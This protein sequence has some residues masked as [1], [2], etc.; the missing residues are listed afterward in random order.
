MSGRGYIAEEP[1]TMCAFCGT[2][3]ECRP[4]GADHEQICFD[5]AMSTPERKAMAERRMAEYI[6]GEVNE[7]NN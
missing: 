3:T 7:P 4:Y 5:C 1:D 2:I 6:F